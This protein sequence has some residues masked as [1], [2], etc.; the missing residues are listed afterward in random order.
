MGSPQLS[1]L[2]PQA[3]PSESQLLATHAGRA[4]S[5]LDLARSGADSAKSAESSVCNSRGGV[6]SPPQ[7]AIKIRTKNG[8]IELTS[9]K[10]SPLYPACCVIEAPICTQIAPR[11]RC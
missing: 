9:V 5:G 6:D 10:V 2:D 4:I 8:R 3:R 7:P 11:R 1:T